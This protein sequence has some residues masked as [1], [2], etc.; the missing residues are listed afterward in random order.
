MG[1]TSSW[2]LWTL[3]F[4]LSMSVLTEVAPRV[5]ALGLEVK[6]LF[7][8]HELDDHPSP[9]ELA[10]ALMTPKPTITFLVKRMEA[11]GYVKRELQPNDLRRFKLTLTPA[12]RKAME[13]A[14]AVLEETFDQRLQKLTAPQRAELR[15]LLERMTSA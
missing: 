11:A 15:R 6:E 8:L 4:Q 3:N 10:Q 9:A 14:R 5:R 7:L 1:K 13:K 2:E 12:G